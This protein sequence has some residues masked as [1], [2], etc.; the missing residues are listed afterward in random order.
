MQF[1][2]TQLYNTD[3][4]CLLPRYVTISIQDGSV[5]LLYQE[6]Q[7]IMKCNIRIK[8]YQY[9]NN[10]NR[11]NV[12]AIKSQLIKTSITCW[13]N[14]KGND[15]KNS[16]AQTTHFMVHY[17]SI[18]LHQWLCI[19]RRF[20]IKHFIHANTEGP[21]VTLGAILS[22]PIFHGL[23]DFWWDVVWCSN[24][25][26]RLNLKGLADSRWPNCLQY[27]VYFSR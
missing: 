16:K 1:L 9:K 4:I 11:Q 20:S 5:G 19:K 12:G 23:Q 17:L 18:S 10:L 2:S 26:R 8:Y 7:F 15:L 3:K 24:C 21:P 22:F 25:Y 6:M 13:L 14:C 27:Y